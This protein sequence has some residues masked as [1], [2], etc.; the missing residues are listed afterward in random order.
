M[1]A[2]SCNIPDRDK[3]DI[4]KKLKLLLVALAGAGLLAGCILCSC[5]PS[6]ST[7][8]CEHVWNEG[9]VTIPA[10]CADAGVMTFSCTLCDQTKTK[11]IPVD[12]TAHR[13]D[14]GS[15]TSAPTCS[16]KGV[17]T[18]VCT[19]DP[20]HT[21][22][23][24]LPE[25]PDVHL[26]SGEWQHDAF[27]HWHSAVCGHE[28]RRD[29]AEHSWE[30]DEVLTAATCTSEGVRRL[31][32][33]CGATKTETIGIDPAAHKYARAWTASEEGHYHTATCGH[34][35]HSEVIPHTPDGGRVTKAPDC[36]IAGETTFTCT[37][38]KYATTQ[39]IAPREHA[40]DSNV[41]QHD[42]AGHWH[43]AT[44]A[45]GSSVDH[46]DVRGSY[47]VHQF[48]GNVCKICNF[49][50]AL[51]SFET[52]GGEVTITGFAEGVDV[53]TLTDLYIPDSYEEKPV[54]AIKAGKSGAPTFAG[55]VALKTISL[56]A[57]LTSVGNYAF[58]GEACITAL[59]W[60]GTLEKY[61]NIN[62]GAN[63]SHPFGLG[64]EK[65]FLGTDDLRADLYVD[66]SLLT[67]VLLP[68]TA[69]KIPAYAF[70]RCDDITAVTFPDSSALRSIGERA[71]GYLDKI[72]RVNV[73][74][75]VTSIGSGAFAMC[76]SLQALTLPFVGGSA[77]AS[78]A[79]ASTLLGHLFNLC[80]WTTV[81]LPEKMEGFYHVQQSFKEYA[82]NIRQFYAPAALTSITVTGGKL[83]YGAFEGMKELSQLS[84]PAGLSAIPSRCFEGCE[85]LPALDI[86]NNVQ[87][88]GDNAF[89]GMKLL[90]NI[91]LGNCLTA[92]GTSAFARCGL[93]SI[94]FP[95]TLRSV[96]K[97]MDTS[98]SS[99][100]F[101]ECTQLKKVYTDSLVA[102][103]GIEFFGSNVNNDPLAPAGAQLYVGDSS[104]PL[105]ELVIP[106]EVTRLSGCAF[107]GCTGLS[108]I[109]IGAQVT[110]IGSSC[111]AGIT[112]CTINFETPT[113]WSACN[114]ETSSS[115]TAVEA[116]TLTATP[117][118]QFNALYQYRYLKKF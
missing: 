36:G 75:G 90:K 98:F 59:Y 43:P 102:W 29:K 47:E 68:A 118:E 113:G 63:N 112:G 28:A 40:F 104:E 14:N 108:S 3:E 11:E 12:P 65:P 106:A 83:F 38:C 25:E 100:V 89:Y 8:D 94:R 107:A 53:S 24:E 85:K 66:G 88:I 93:E 32:C 71:F 4:M 78:A 39:P 57:S 76:R 109:T 30:E 5:G 54:T 49:A 52:S 1:C 101:S 61:L 69:T 48:S 58:E 10:T 18:Y 16:Q 72:T 2:T 37:V 105:K 19:A 44:C 77:T 96:G 50:P 70:Y 55:A 35:V 46:S 31:K 7:G 42:A 110:K 17:K 22:T 45:E 95:A 114:M 79:S 115:G 67:E 91:D 64:I 27:G 111:F 84:L 34:S 81:D 51:L 116:S 92:I 13:W 117:V 15:V 103:C 73:P 60:R 21:K 6:Q 41:W 82:A 87:T 99:A 97:K 62:F 56:P 86:G 9:T 26:F 33:V 23:E 80:D 20:T 74:A